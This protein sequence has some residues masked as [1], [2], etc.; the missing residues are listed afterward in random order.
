[1]V[2]GVHRCVRDEAGAFRP[3]ARWLI[4]GLVQF[5]GALMAFGNRAETSFLRL[6]QGKEAPQSIC[7]G[8]FD[9]RALIRLPIVPVTRDGREVGPPT[10]EYRLPD[11]SAHP[12]LLLAGVAQAMLQGRDTADLDALLEATAVAAGASRAATRA[13]PVPRHPREVAEAL[14]AHRGGLQAGGVFPDVLI[15]EVLARLGA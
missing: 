12:Y 13:A 1:V 14:A 10:V 4:A 3:E 8:E 15:D 11:G 2:G 5:G 6:S 9:R 7:W